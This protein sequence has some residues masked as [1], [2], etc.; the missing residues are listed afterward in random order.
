ME[1]GLGIVDASDDEIELLISRRA[2]PVWTEFI[3]AQMIS[4]RA[5]IGVAPAS[6]PLPPSIMAAVLADFLRGAKYSTHGHSAVDVNI[7]A[8]GDPLVWDKLRGNHENTEIGQFIQDYLE[9]DLEAVTEILNQ[10]GG[11]EQFDTRVEEE[12]D[13]LYDQREIHSWHH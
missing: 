4:L 10:D 3:L 8:A 11:I 2:Y 12:K 13:D 6:S 5:R 9:L 7:Y 1:Q